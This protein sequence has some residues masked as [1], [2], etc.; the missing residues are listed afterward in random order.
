[1]A[2]EVLKSATVCV[3]AVATNEYHTSSLTPVAEQEGAVS[4]EAVDASVDAVTALEQELSEEMVSPV[5]LIQ[6][7]F[8]GGDTTQISKLL[9]VVL[10]AEVEYTLTRYVL[11][12]VRPVAFAEPVVPLPHASSTSEAQVPE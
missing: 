7:L 4:T 11:P 5:A 2:K 9:V 6:S 1:V 12:I 10:T 8:A 3:V